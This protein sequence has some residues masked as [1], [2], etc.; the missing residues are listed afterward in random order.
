MKKL[1]RVNHLTITPW[2]SFSVIVTRHLWQLLIRNLPTDLNYWPL[3]S[4]LPFDSRE[5][6]MFG[7]QIS[8]GNFSSRLWRFLHP[9]V[10]LESNPVASQQREKFVQMAQVLDG[11][12]VSSSSSFKNV[13]SRKFK[14]LSPSSQIRGLACESWGM[15]FFLVLSV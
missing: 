8:G 1:G 5:N 13:S 3:R 12:S 9:H 4:L 7:P 6:S 2:A 10:R 14:A 15:V 11:L